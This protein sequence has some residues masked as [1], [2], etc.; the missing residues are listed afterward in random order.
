VGV[1]VQ[2]FVDEKV[3]ATVDVAVEV[4]VEVKLGVTV[5]VKSGVAVAVEVGLL[6]RVK[7]PVATKV[8]VGTGVKV[9]GLLGLVGLEL[10]PPHPNEKDMVKRDKEQ[11]S[12]RS[13]RTMAPFL[14]GEKL[15][16]N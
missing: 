2:L 3:D 1:V 12:V 7:V 8:L 9:G 15:S 11:K 6:K 16:F 5:E 13:F 4:A 10:P 14:Y